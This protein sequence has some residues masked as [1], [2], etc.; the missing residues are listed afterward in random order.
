MHLFK[1]KFY[2]KAQEKSKKVG[3]NWVK[4]RN[5]LFSVH[6]K[7]P[8][9]QNYSRE[10]SGIRFSG[11]SRG[12]PGGNSRES[13]L[14]DTYTSRIKVLSFC[15]LMSGRIIFFFTVQVKY[16]KIQID[17]GF[18]NN[19]IISHAQTPFQTFPTHA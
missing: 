15:Y 7:F 9:I 19:K 16:R 18:R 3:A 8:V 17:S 10:F 4:I 13:T 1:I 11:N 5:F 6:E 14:K 2:L 12:F